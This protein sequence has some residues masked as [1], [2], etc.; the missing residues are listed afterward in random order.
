M[1]KDSHRLPP[2]ELR[3]AQIT[4]TNFAGVK[5]QF[6]E[7]GR[8]NF[9]VLLDHDTAKSMEK[10]GWRVKY[11]KPRDEGDEEQAYLQVKVNYGGYKPPMVSMIAGNKIKDLDESTIDI[12][13]RVD[14]DYCDMVLNPSYFEMPDGMKGYTAYL[15]ELYVHLA[16]SRLSQEYA[17]AYRKDI[18]ENYVDCGHVC[19]GDCDTCPEAV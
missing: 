11:L 1:A 14:I 15:G 7:A 19:N 17:E 13:D 16:I 9:C 6:N 2:V 4:F 5:R 12:L 8:R 3:N 10:D 18:E